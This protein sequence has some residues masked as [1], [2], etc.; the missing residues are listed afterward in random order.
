MK[1]KNSLTLAGIAILIFLISVAMSARIRI[2]EIAPT[3]ES[4]QPIGVG[5]IRLELQPEKVQ[6][7]LS[8]L[9][10]TFVLRNSSPESIEIESYDGW[11]QF[12][13]FYFFDDKGQSLGKCEYGLPKSSSYF[14]H[15]ES[16]HPTQSVSCPVFARF[17]FPQEE[18]SYFVEASFNYKNI[19]IRSNR[20]QFTI[21]KPPQQQ[22][23]PDL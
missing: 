2:V 3:I 7:H 23:V 21:R 1:T 9:K 20:E 18:N 10:G 17:P 12:V 15:K 8:H 4:E 19:H 22:E 16:L 5:A 14:P 11:R 13:D 6:W